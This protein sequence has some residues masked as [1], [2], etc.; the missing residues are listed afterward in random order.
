MPRNADLI[1]RLLIK[2][3]C[4]YSLDS[5]DLFDVE[6]SQTS[7]FYVSFA[8]RWNPV[9][10]AALQRSAMSIE[11]GIDESRTPAVLC[12]GATAPHEVTVIRARIQTQV[13]FPT[14]PQGNRKLPV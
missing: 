5:F 9:K 2:L 4:Y 1:K 7:L 3:I 13:R 11:N 10:N 12:V 6:F 8:Y 14:G